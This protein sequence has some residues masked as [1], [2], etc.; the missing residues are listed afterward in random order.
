MQPVVRIKFVRF[1]CYLLALSLSL[2]SVAGAAFAGVMPVY[3]NDS[4]MQSDSG[5]ERLDHNDHHQGWTKHSVNNQPG[6]SVVQNLHG[7]FLLTT[8]EH[9][10]PHDADADCDLICSMGSSIMSSVSVFPRTIYST[11]V[12]VLVGYPGFDS[13][14]QKVLIRPPRI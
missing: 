14:F 7:K 3:G 12:W 5:K 2:G 9:K 6:S 13:R 11:Q 10:E 1:V 8:T 4:M